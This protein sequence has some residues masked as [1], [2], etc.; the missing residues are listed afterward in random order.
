M[1]DGQLVDLW[2]KFKFVLQGLVGAAALFLFALSTGIHAGT[3]VYPAIARHAGPL[4]LTHI[5]VL[6][7]FFSYAFLTEKTN[8]IS[9]K[10]FPTWAQVV[11]TALFGYVF[12][13]IAILFVSSNTGGAHGDVFD[14]IN[15]TMP[16]E[17]S[18][19]LYSRDD[20]YGLRFFSVIWMLFSFNLA[21]ASFYCNFTARFGRYDAV[22]KRI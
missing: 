3:W 2:K 11:S 19:Q 1:K 7:S 10:D 8:R 22:V 5:A 6:I 16:L 20:L 15:K 17:K 4:M 21:T 14:S 13:S 18:S 9:S 12:L